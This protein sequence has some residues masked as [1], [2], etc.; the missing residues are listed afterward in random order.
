MHS[1]AIFKVHILDQ[2]LHEMQLEE[3]KT[4]LILQ[5]VQYMLMQDQSSK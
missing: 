2:A 1:R 4:V 5:L 3:K